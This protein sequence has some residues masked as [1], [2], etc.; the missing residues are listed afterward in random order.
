[1]PDLYSRSHTIS[2][3][4]RSC[5]YC[6]L[7]TSYTHPQSMSPINSSISLCTKS[8]SLLIV[9]RHTLFF[10]FRSSIHTQQYLRAIRIRPRI[11]P[12]IPCEKPFVYAIILFFKA[13]FLYPL[14]SSTS[15]ISTSGSLRAQVVCRIHNLIMPCYNVSN[16]NLLI[17]SW[18]SLFI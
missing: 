7:F 9:Y 15:G 8:I 1:M 10:L 5:L 13:R 2:I 17:M 11:S 14:R 16:Q 18:R 4:T 6:L 12:F 3:A